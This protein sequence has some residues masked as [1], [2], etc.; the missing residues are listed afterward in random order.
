MTIV[1]ASGLPDLFIQREAQRAGATFAAKPLTREDLLAAVYRTALRRPNP[2]GG[3]EPI[4]P[5]FE[6]RHGERRRTGSEAGSVAE[7]RC[8]ERRRDIAELLRRAAVL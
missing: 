2:E 3:F 4:E 7:R 1:V 8:V 6:R 5:P